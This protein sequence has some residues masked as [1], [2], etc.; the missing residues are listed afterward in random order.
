MHALSQRTLHLLVVDRLG[1][2]SQID[3]DV[4]LFPWLIAI[5]GEQMAKSKKSGKPKREEQ[6]DERIS[7]SGMGYEF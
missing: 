5:D 6:R 7:M 4:S 3:V 2:S 1:T